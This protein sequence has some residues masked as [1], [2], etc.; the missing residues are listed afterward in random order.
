MNTLDAPYFTYGWLQS[1]ESMCFS[2]LALWWNEHFGRLEICS[3]TVG[4]HMDLVEFC[5]V[6][7]TSLGSVI[8]LATGE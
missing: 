3:H 5:F 8:L 2:L 4:Q 7:A 1:S 6:L